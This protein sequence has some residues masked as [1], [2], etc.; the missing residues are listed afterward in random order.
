MSEILYTNGRDTSDPPFEAPLY[1]PNPT[2]NSFYRLLGRLIA[3]TVR[4]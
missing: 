2:E 1:A 3:F 4:N